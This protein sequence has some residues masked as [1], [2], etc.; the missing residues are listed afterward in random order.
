M[1]G[2]VNNGTSDDVCDCVYE[3]ECDGVINDVSGDEGY[4][5][6]VMIRWND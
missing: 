3:G 5:L 6:K 2:C 4:E 1:G